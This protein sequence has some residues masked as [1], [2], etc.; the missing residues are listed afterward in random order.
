MR[1]GSFGEIRNGY[2]AGWLIVWIK[3]A[4]VGLQ[5]RRVQFPFYITDFNQKL[6][7]KQ[8]MECGCKWKKNLGVK[9]IKC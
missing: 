9:W 3:K 6:T 1:Y 4:C 2:L 8:K 7:P 5:L